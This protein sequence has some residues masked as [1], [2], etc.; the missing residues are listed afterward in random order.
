MCGHLGRWGAANIEQPLLNCLEIRHT[1]ERHR[2]SLNFLYGV[3]LKVGTREGKEWEKMRVKRNYLSF[4]EG[5]VK[6]DL[7]SLKA[8][9]EI[10]KLYVAGDLQVR[11]Q[12]SDDEQKEVLTWVGNQRRYKI[13]SLK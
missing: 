1:K 7:S 11:E 13:T 2:S 6:R 8:R 5:T 9:R 10:N 12:F 3:F 4:T